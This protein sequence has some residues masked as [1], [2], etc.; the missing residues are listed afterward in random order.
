MLIPIDRETGKKK[1]KLTDAEKKDLAASIARASTKP[2]VR[3]KGKH[4]GL[5]NP[6]P[7]AKAKEKSS[8]SRS[9]R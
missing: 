8:G 4:P 3:S 2:K 6:K 9:S 7:V 5:R 1:T